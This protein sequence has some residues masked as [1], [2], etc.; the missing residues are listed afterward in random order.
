MTEWLVRCGISLWTELCGEPV[1]QLSN[2][3]VD[4]AGS[5]R[6]SDL[7]YVLPRRIISPRSTLNSYGLSGYLPVDLRYLSFLESFSLNDNQLAGPVPGEVGQHTAFKYLSFI[8]NLLSGTIPVQ[9]GHLTALEVTL[10][11]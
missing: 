11:S 5:D 9:V 7:I 6:L 2:H 8:I 4:V 10:I 1:Q 3:E